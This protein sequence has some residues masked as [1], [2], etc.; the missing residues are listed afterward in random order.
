M[1]QQ[2]LMRERVCGLYSVRWILCW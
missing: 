2:F 1:T